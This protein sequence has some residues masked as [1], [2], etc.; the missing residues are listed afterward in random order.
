VGTPLYRKPHLIQTIN[1]V[2]E[3][4]DECKIVHRRPITKVHISSQKVFS[5]H[6]SI[7]QDWMYYELE[8]QRLEEVKRGVE[9][10][11]LKSPEGL[12]QLQESALVCQL[13]LEC[14]V[15]PTED[16]SILIS[17]L[18]H[19]VVDSGATHHVLFDKSM[20]A[21]SDFRVVQGEQY[22]RTGGGEKHPLK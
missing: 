22:V 17:G 20:F 7:R 18:R 11:V 16:V 19:L 4:D 8:M 1:Q 9:G 14:G 2:E 6:P 10:K 12:E 13:D 21:A 15:S 5:A 3:D